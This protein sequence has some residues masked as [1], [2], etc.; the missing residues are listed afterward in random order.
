MKRIFYFLLF[1]IFL[2]LGY[3][4]FLDK[5][6]DT[7]KEIDKIVVIK[8]E[9]KLIVYCETEELKSYT[10][11][12]GREPKGAK[13]F[14]GDMKTPE[15]VYF[16]ESKNPHSNYFLNLGISYP[17]KKDVLY[18]KKCKKSPGGLIK[19]HGLRNGL[20]FI[21]KFHQWFDWTYGCIAVTNEEMQELY[22]NVKIGTIIEIKL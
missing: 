4:F 2:F 5:K 6:L 13:H 16:I 9:R 22:E 7:S 11:S 20:G 21:G 12:L 1:V 18:A 10:V 3:Y 14:E 8:S 17:E 15:G 19:I